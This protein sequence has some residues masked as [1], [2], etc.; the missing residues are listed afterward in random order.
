[1]S[2][3]SK[4]G[5]KPNVVCEHAEA[6]IDIRFAAKEDLEAT[7]AA[8]RAITEKSYVYNDLLKA[9]TTA[10]VKTLVSKSSMPA[11]R[12]ARLF[13]LLEVA[14]KK[15]NQ[16]VSGR[17]VGYTSDANDLAD[18]GMDLLV[19]LGPYGTGMHTDG[20]YLSISTFDQRRELAEALIREVLK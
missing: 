17:H 15:V 20:E 2:A 4:E 16:S 19:G 6:G 11:S 3:S 5:T 10:S 9:G 8:I 13:G 18:T 1:M 14:G 7:L 12:T